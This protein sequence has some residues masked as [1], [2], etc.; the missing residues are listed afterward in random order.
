MPKFLV[1]SPS[2]K[3]YEVN[4][5][6][7]ATLEQAIAYA[8]RLEAQEQE[9]DKDKGVGSRFMSGLE[10]MISSGRAAIESLSDAE[11][12]ALAAAER[13]RRIFEKYGEGA[14]L[15]DLK[16]AY[17]ERGALGA[18]G[19]VVSSVPGA[20]AEQVPQMGATIAGASAGSALGAAA[21]PVGA[22]VG[23]VA[24]AV[25]P[26]FLQQ[27]GSNIQRQAEE[28]IAAGREVDV[29]RGAAA[30]AAV[31]Q[32]ALDVASQ[33]V[34]VGRVLGK[35]LFGELGKKVDD[36]LAKGDTEA[37]EKLAK[38]GL[39]ETLAKGT[40][41]GVAAEV[42]T[43]VVQ[44]A[45]E[46]AQAGLPITG[47]DAYKEYGEVA[48]RTSLMAP[49]GGVGRFADRYSARAK[50][51]EAAPSADTIPETPEQI[52]AAKKE[53]EAAAKA[54]EPPL[55]SSI[56]DAPPALRTEL[57]SIDTPK[58]AAETLR[59]AE[60]RLVNL[61]EDLAD[62]EGM[63]ADAKRTGISPVELEQRLMGVAERLQEAIPFYRLRLQELS[64][65]PTSP[66]P[67][68]PVAPIPQTPAAQQTFQI[69][70]PLAKAINVPGA[71][72]A[73]K[74]QPVT[75]TTS[76]PPVSPIPQVAGAQ[77]A[78]PIETTAFE[79]PLYRDAVDA[80]L[81][82]GEPTTRTIQEATG[83][84]YGRAKELLEK[85]ELE[86][87][88]TAPQKG[89]RT[90]TMGQPKETPSATVE[91]TP[92]LAEPTVSGAVGRSP[93]LPLPGPEP[94]RPEVAGVAG[95]GLGVAPRTAADVIEREERVEPALGDISTVVPPEEAAPKEKL[96]NPFL[97]RRRGVVPPSPVMAKPDVEQAAAES[98][99]GWR[100][101]PEVVVLDNENDARI[102]RGV[103]INPDDKGF[104]HQGKTYVIAS[105]ATD[106]AD[107]HATVLHESLGHFGLQQKFRTRLNDILSDIYD[108]NPATRAAADAIKTPGMSNAQA[109]EEVLA[110]RA[111]AGPIKEAGIRAAFNRVAAF[112]RRV[113]RAMGIKF[114]YS[115]NDVTQ[116]MRL[117]Q[118]KVIS[119]KREVAGLRSVA[120]AKRLQRKLLDAPLG[121]M[122]AT[123]G[124]P[125]NWAEQ[126]EAAFEDMS[127]KSRKAFL[128]LR[129][130]PEMVDV[131]GGKL[132]ALKG[133]VRVV[134][135]K[136]V[137]LREMRDEIGNNISKW[138]KVLNDK[139]YRGVTINKFYRIAL[140]S[141]EEQIDF[142][143]EITVNGKK[144]TNPDYKP[145]NKLTQEFESLPK[146]LRDVYFDML[147]AYRKMADMYIQLITQ[148]L[149]PTAANILRKQ[150]ESR[151][152]KVYLPLF[153]EGNYWLRYE[154]K[155]K[156]FVESYKS[157]RKR[158]L[159]KQEL[160]ASGIPENSIQEYAK[161]ED[162][163]EVPGASSLGFFNDI[164]KVLDDYYRD[165][166]GQPAPAELK[167]TLYSAFLD[168]IPA[169]SV[170]Q[171]F[172]KREGYSG[173]DQDLIKVYATIASRMASQL[174]NLEYTPQIDEAVKLLKE[175]VAKDGTTAAQ[176]V[177]AEIGKRLSFLRDPTSPNW[178]NQF[179]F[180]SYAD[181]I[182]GNMSSAFFNI[183]NIGTTVYPM[184][185]GEYG[186]GKTKTAIEDAM[187]M[188]LQGGWDDDGKAG[189]PKK[190]PEADR[191]AFDPKKIPPNS[192]LGRLY[193]E[194][195]KR[196]AIKHSVGYDI[197]E[198]RDRDIT[199]KDY[200]GMLNYSKQLMGW[201]FQNT[202][203]FNREVSLIATF[204]LEMEKQLSLGRSTRE[205][206]QIAI[207]KAIRLSDRANSETLT[208]LS[209]RIFQQPVL[210]VAL[211]FKRYARAMYALQLSLLRDALEG[212]K[213]DTTGMNPQEKAE[214][215]AVDR[216]FRKVA[217]KQWLGTVGG[218][219][220]FA[221]IQGLPFYGLATTLAAGAGALS[222]AMFGEADDEI[223]DSEEDFEQAIGSLWMRG[224][225]S[226]LFGVD[227]ASR[228]GFNGMFWRDDPRRLDEIGLQLFAIEQ[229][230]GAPYAMVRT[231]GEAIYDMFVAGELQ[232][233]LEKLAPVAA[234]NIM[235]TF[236]YMTDG[237][238]TRDGKKITEDL[239]AYELFMQAFGFTPTQIQQASA[240]AGARKEIVDKVRERRQAF[241]ENAYAQWSQGNQEGFEKALQDISKWNN[242]KTAAEFNATI[243]WDELEQSFRQRGKAAEEALDGIS[244]PKRYREGAISRVPT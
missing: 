216:E 12:A 92:G 34:V 234:R 203:R 67:A 209:P 143:P 243:D 168:T 244:I 137:K 106:K 128:M 156:T 96:V 210:K 154:V 17:G 117:A 43:E 76:A 225:A 4:G 104:Y 73:P 205:A 139:Q 79:D 169:S 124:R 71:E 231:K 20:I 181:F 75:V 32:A 204:R 1:T 30:A 5:P 111:E 182:L 38:E 226:E 189:K 60:T 18:A 165:R 89:I 190:F 155:G 135:E 173:A 148:N 138:N 66:A 229:F 16:R 129:S 3:K 86:G 50:A 74:D 110:S 94:T 172:R 145:T 195:I 153:R 84:G 115:N 179:V 132:P 35:K 6:P 112:I 127:D 232:R 49:L 149:P 136:V 219:F 160:V 218:A 211:T 239:D 217:I 142:R 80:V 37:A 213:I 72:N 2:G 31:P 158:K 151:R 108:T 187:A 21:G 188:F 157:N 178:V 63:E 171:Q 147:D 64:G 164:N 81:Q 33:F 131:F 177:Q 105:R 102:P 224:P 221:G 207:D 233:G 55:P 54:K 162:A 228:T 193:I 82:S 88:V 200:A 186:Y 176:Q 103:T 10:S 87:V 185:G 19:E 170:R 61:S 140:A 223:T 45:L 130:L 122:K 242:T 46:R 109:V 120:E 41:V 240:R 101:A 159:A 48:Y 134:T 116:V 161:I 47:D 56:N 237:V 174:T 52:E 146:P 26:S 184:L 83:V 25:A 44:Q 152:L 208:E 14:S 9:R 123:G 77:V 118:E 68:A 70:Q 144:R 65:T 206:E 163:F 167:N 241:M 100:N 98:V 90:I 214:A 107:V 235:K 29:S 113:A 133:L 40:A 212:S 197:I 39:T 194:A 141:T 201:T 215:E 57:Q 85:M 198:A 192:P 53:E 121:A 183:S 36:L 78:L 99:Q 236:R 91:T 166:L 230:L 27:Y 114:A 202:E 42:P 58:K 59:A 7:G 62:V 199:D 15:E 125:K 69:D 238:L 175:D 126:T 191:T 97:A 220:V 150:I 11:K 51:R 22:L 119:G 28:D 227:F 196:G 95:E 222:A 180:W 23:S 93:E 8:Q 13:N 24:G